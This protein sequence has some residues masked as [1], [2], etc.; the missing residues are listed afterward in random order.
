VY[1]LAGRETSVTQAYGTSNATTTSY[2]YDAAGRK[3]GETDALTHTT[4]Y[5]YD[6]AGNLTGISGPK[7]NFSYAYDNARN[8]VSMTDGNNHTTQYRYD[9]RKRLTTTIYPDQTTKTNAYDG[10]GNLVS[11]TDQAGNVVAYTYDAANQLQTVVQESH[12]DPSQNTNVYGY[13]SLGDLTGLADENGHTTQNAYNLLMEPVTKTLPDGTLTESRSYDQ[14]GN[15][16]TV[17]HFNGATTTYTY[18]NLNRLLSRA[19]PGETTV[20]FTYTATGKRQTMTDAS[21]TTNYSYD[22]MDR[23]TSKATPEGTLS[24]TYD[25]AGN[26]ASMTS[27][28]GAVNVAYNWNDLNLLQT[29]VDSRLGTTTYTYDNANNVFTVAYPNG[30]TTTYGY[31]QL[32]RVSGLG[33][34]TQTGVYTYG[35]D[36]AG[37]LTAASEPSGRQVVWNYDGINRL[38]QE[39]ISSAPSGKNGNL[40]YGL[41]PVGNRTS[42]TSISGLSPISGTFNQDDEMTSSEGYGDGNGNVTSAVTAAGSKTFAYNS[43]NQLVSMGSTVG[44]VYDGDGNRVS[45]TVSGATT[46]YL[47]DDLNPTGYPQ[48]V[49][50]LT[51]GATSRTYTYGLQR[52]SQYQQVNGAWTPSFY[53]YDGGG[54]V[55]QLTNIAGAVTDRYEYDAFGNEFTVSGGSNTPNEMMY[56]GEQFDSDL[57]LYYLRARYYNP[58]TGRF[59][60]FD[61]NAGKLID[62]KTL[63][64]YLYANGDPV[65]RIDPHGREAMLEVGAIDYDFILETLPKVVQLACAVEAIYALEAET[66]NYITKD[67]LGIVPEEPLP[68]PPHLPSILCGIIGFPAL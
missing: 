67:L 28:D 31:D 61:P 6:N 14:A 50:E 3:T 23:L 55:R 64:K 57:G 58:A 4:T 60:S 40:A 38:T 41:D 48:V 24:Y 12:P 52:I 36:N 42:A 2:A 34:T 35:R 22:S 44:L 8:R 56:R 39:T 16:S 25:G 51:N 21:G 32:N 13:D 19:T 43:Q 62:P 18:D 53:Q 9:A 49:E 10:P 11:V 46:R 37:K 45:K 17:T 27:G 33:Y 20:S 26:V 15:L 5:S 30:V 65:N 63:H 54:N 47:V 1:D 59:L 68:S 7:G 29:A 66:I